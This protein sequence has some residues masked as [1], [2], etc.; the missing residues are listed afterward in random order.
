MS[1]LT[2][3]LDGGLAAE[4]GDGWIFADCAVCSLVYSTVEL[5]NAG[6]KAMV[7]ISKFIVTN[8]VQWRDQKWCRLTRGRFLSKPRYDLLP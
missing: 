6:M 4:S 3:A 7:V 2:V 1:P 8:K 5:Y